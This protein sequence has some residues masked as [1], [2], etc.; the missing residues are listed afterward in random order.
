MKLLILN[1]IQPKIARFWGDENVV[2]HVYNALQKGG[3]D[4]FVNSANT[5]K[6]VELLLQSIT[7]DLVF[8]NGCWL[9]DDDG[10]PYIAEVLERNEMPY[11]GSSQYSLSRIMSKQ[12]TKQN[13]IDAGL[14]TPNFVVFSSSYDFGIAAKVNFP[15]TAWRK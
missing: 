14:P 8:A 5:R 2:I 4:V 11:I 9:L 6:Q 12:V 15:S 13:L 1:T 10:C 3:L 7:P